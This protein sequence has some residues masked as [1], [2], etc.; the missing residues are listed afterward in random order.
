[1]EYV[2]LP[3]CGGSIFKS[4]A[5]WYK[6][7]IYEELAFIIYKAIGAALSTLHV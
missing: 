5:T 1:M 6:K 3:L 7:K 2:F 4:I